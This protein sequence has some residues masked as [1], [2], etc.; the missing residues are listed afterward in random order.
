MPSLYAVVSEPSFK[1]SSSLHGLQSDNIDIDAVWP[2]LSWP[3]VVVS[4]FAQRFFRIDVHEA[5]KIVLLAGHV[6][7]SYIVNLRP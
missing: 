3:G 6:N 1:K 2:V 7:G 4:P 5:Q